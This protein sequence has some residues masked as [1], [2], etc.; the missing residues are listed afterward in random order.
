MRG[1][2]KQAEMVK[3]HTVKRLE[4]VGALTGRNAHVLLLAFGGVAE[5]PNALVLKT[6]DGRPSVGSNPTPS[7]IQEPA[8]AECGFF[9]G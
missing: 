4:C 7:A 2:P 9:Y 5:W 1:A 8:L 3:I 6:S